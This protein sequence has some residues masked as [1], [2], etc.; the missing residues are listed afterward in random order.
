MSK[1]IYHILNF[2]LII[3]WRLLKFIFFIIGI[4]VFLVVLYSNLE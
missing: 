1:Q 2:L 3:F 4:I